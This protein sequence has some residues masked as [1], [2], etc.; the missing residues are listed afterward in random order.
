MALNRK[1]NFGPDEDE[2]EVL[3]G[4]H[5]QLW[6]DFGNL[7][8]QYEELEKQSADLKREKVNI[9][10]QRNLLQEKIQTLEERAKAAP[11]PSPVPRKSSIF[12]II[13]AILVGARLLLYKVIEGWGTRAVDLGNV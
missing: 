6:K 11:A 13:A 2:R 10:R 5:A 1:L 7:K 4:K 12:L 3:R 9:H 8:V